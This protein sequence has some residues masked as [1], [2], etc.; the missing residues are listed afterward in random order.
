MSTVTPHE[1]PA[2]GAPRATSPH[3][4]ASTGAASEEP[5]PAHARLATE[6]MDP[7]TDPVGT[8]TDEAPDKHADDVNEPWDEPLNPLVAVAAGTSEPA[9][10][11][12]YDVASGTW[13]WSPGMFALHGFETGEVDP[14]T[15]LLMAHKHPEDLLATEDT[16]RGVLTTGEPFCCRHRVVDSRG[17]VREVLSVGEG[18]CDD[19]GNVVAVQGYFVDLTHAFAAQAD[20]RPQAAHSLEHLIALE[21]AKGILIG[22]FRLSAT[23]ALELLRWRSEETGTDIE[24]IAQGLVAEFVAVEDDDDLSPA[25]RACSFLGLNPLEDD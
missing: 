23:A 20:A 11:F 7:P 18:F 22:A 3:A 9:A 21:Q 13:W 1:A 17:R 12:R 2:T 14:S 4:P 10:R 6:T 24:V 16:L 19:D 15:D 8:V 25:R 5:A